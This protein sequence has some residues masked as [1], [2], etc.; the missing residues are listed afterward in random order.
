MNHTAGAFDANHDFIL[1]LSHG[2]DGGYFDAKVL[3]RCSGHISVKT[4]NEGSRLFARGFTR[5][6]GLRIGSLLVRAIL[7]SMCL[8]TAFFWALFCSALG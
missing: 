3:Y 5:F 6:C 2:E 4:N 8:A 7:G 1:R